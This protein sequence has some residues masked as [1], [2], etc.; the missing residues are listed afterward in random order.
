M[1][2]ERKELREDALRPN[3]WTRRV[4]ARLGW[5]G[6]KL[7]CL[8]ILVGY[9]LFYFVGL[10]VTLW[11]ANLP[12]F[13]QVVGEEA[14]MQRL[15]ARAEE[16][17][18]NGD[19]DGAALHSGKAALMAAQLAAQHHEPAVA[20]LYRG[21]E[22]L[23]RAQEHVYRAQALFQRAG[24][25]LPASS[26]VCGTLRMAD[27]KVAEATKRLNEEP[28]SAIDAGYRPERERLRGQTA[29]WAQTIDGMA[30]DFQCR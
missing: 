25:Q 18:A 3:P 17:I 19:A 16:A 1:K 24:G 4:L 13:A 11:G 23:F 21:A 10:A 29:D 22:A 27:L 20:G 5:A 9:R 12:L 15:Q 26:G 6:V 8:N 30:K 2:R 7:A 28:V 14:E